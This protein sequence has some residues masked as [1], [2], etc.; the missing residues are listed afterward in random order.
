LL[1]VRDD[2]IDERHRVD[3]T[4]LQPIGRLAGASYAYVHEIFDMARGTYNP[5]TGEVEYPKLGG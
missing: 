3:I 1:H 5:A 4:R 2:L